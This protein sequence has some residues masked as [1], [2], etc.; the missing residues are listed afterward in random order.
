MQFL[1]TLSH[2]KQVIILNVKF[3]I[4]EKIRRLIDFVFYHH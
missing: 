1:Q 4:A 3:A 2:A